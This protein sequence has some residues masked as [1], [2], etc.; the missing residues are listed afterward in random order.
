MVMTDG[1]HLV[2]D[3]VSE[4]HG[5]AGRIG[6]RRSWFQGGSRHP[7]YDILSLSVQKRALA[8]GAVACD[9]RGLLLMKDKGGRDDIY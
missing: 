7:H 6:L 3:S 4:L 2:A 5:F 9:T 1:V 8:E